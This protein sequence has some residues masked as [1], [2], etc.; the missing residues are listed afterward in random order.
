MTKRVIFRCDAGDAPEIGTGHIV[1]S[2]NI[3]RTL[4]AEGLL[5]TSDILFLTRGDPD[6]CLGEQYL[7]GSGLR[8]EVLSDFQLEPNSLSEISV[9][10]KYDPDL[11]IIRR[12]GA[13]ER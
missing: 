12:I 2:K 11:V 9:L 13:V 6:F 3:A 4:I 7:S 10:R 8:Y 1:R 5:D